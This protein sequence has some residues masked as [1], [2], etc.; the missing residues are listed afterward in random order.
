MIITELYN[1]QGLGNQLWSYVVTRTLALDRGWEFGIQHPEKFK[2]SSFLQLDFGRPV[3]GGRGPEGGPPEQLPE[4]ILHY[5]VEKEA[6]YE[7]YHCDIRDFDPELLQIK[8][9]TK[10]EG[11]FQSERY[12]AH[13]REEIRKWLRVDPAF[14]CQDFARDNLCVLNVRG[15]EYRGTRELILPRSYW[16]D[17]MAHMRRFRA[18]MEF[19]VVTDD[20]TYARKLLPNYPAYHFDI[21][22]DYAIVKNAHFLILSNSSFG[23]FPAWTSTATQRVIAPKYWARHNISD[24]FWACAFNLY[25]DWL[26]L[27]RDGVL[28][29]YAACAAE[30]T[31]YRNAHQLHACGPWRKSGSGSLPLYRKVLP[32]VWRVASRIKRRIRGY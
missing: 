12:I 27:D 8:D 24:G 22:K 29:D 26:W 1:G 10:I 28:L 13:R 17:A 20:V 21:G 32:G 25:Q 14:D 9:H 2:G 15:G 19:V 6:W 5:Y 18:D 30:Y 23:F 31:Q 4:G 11:Y 7:K 16:E 3:W